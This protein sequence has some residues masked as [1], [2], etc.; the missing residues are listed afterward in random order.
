MSNDAGVYPQVA[1]F[2][3]NRYE[4][5]RQTVEAL[6]NN[7]LAP[8]S[9]LLIFSDAAKSDADVSAVQLVRD[10]IKQIHGFKSVT[11]VE[12]AENFGLARSIIDGVSSTLKR[13]ES[14][15]VLED[16]MVTS[17]H[18]LQFM[19]EG[20]SLYKEHSR[21][22]SIHG[23]VYPIDGLPN[24]FF[25]RGA[26]CWGW[27]TWQDRWEMF[28]A[29]GAALLERLQ[30]QRLVDHFDFNGGYPFS[31]MLKDQIA[32]KNNSW[33]IRWHASV[34]LRNKLTLYPG[35]SLVLNIG[36]DG[37]GAHC[38]DT[39]DFSSDIS[40]QAVSVGN[41]EVEESVTAFTMFERY[42]KMQAGGIV[43]NIRRRLSRLLAGFAK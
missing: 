17:P 21:V 43:K 16:D 23:Y 5:T 33:A 34:F 20:L 11:V 32:G 28:E 19:N 38:G 37:S 29:D 9:D 2:V 10:Y 18:F 14:I 35:K 39:S 27:A 22:A 24:T 25:M 8:S 13:H 42:F 15:I 4:H 30:R 7:A 12:R 31:Q 6:R 26:D 36:N 40:M 1:L 41:I 3:Y